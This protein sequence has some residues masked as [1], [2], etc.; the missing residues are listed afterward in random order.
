MKYCKT[1]SLFLAALTLSVV[2]VSCDD[3]SVTPT[4][5][6]G[7]YGDWRVVSIGNENLQ[8]LDVEVIWTI[9]E[10]T[11]T[12]SDGTTGERVSHGN[13]S[14]DD[15]QD[16]KHIDTEIR[17]IAEEDRRDIY[18]LDGDKLRILFSLDGGKR[19]ADW[20]EGKTMVF[21]RVSVTGTR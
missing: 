7:L 5:T 15:S 9:S 11:I 19:P 18:E 4:P 2:V 16:P 13:Y 1:L 8:D 10:S 20:A 21:E 12:V 6:T 14:T 17:D 3:H